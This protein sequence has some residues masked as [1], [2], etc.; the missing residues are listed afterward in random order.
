[1][2]FGIY[3]GILSDAINLFKFHGVKRLSK[4][5]GR[6][7]LCFDTSGIDAV[8]P[9]PLSVGGLRN[10]GFNQSLLLAKTISDDR[11]I[12]LVIDGL[13]KRFET[14][15]QIGLSAKERARNLK[16]AFIATTTFTNQR[17]MLVDDVITTG[18]TANECS[19]QL[20]AAGASEV[21][22]ITLARASGL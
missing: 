18:A 19:R 3:E 16:G 12:P 6:L 20:I 7:L 4:P 11:E 1:M 22:V 21:V 17:I 14:P 8:I 10:R 13:F 2:S 15:P 9:V 5:L